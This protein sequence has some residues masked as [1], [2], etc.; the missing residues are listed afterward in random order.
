MAPNTGKYDI[1]T[2]IKV[3]SPSS[4]GVT[5]SI[6]GKDGTVMKIWKVTPGES[7]KANIMSTS[8]KQG[9]SLFFIVSAGK[10]DT[11]DSFTW[12]PVIRE[13]ATGR[14]W[15]ASS[16]FNAATA[17]TLESL[18]IQL[19]QALLAANEFAFLD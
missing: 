9:Q 12:N 3:P 17:N 11:S 13:N 18:W 4:D 15:Q 1:S 10:T 6:T 16:A 2:D 19:A 8:L 7:L 5:L 14:S